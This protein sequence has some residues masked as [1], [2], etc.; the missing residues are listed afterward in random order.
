MAFYNGAVLTHTI[1]PTFQSRTRT[2]FRINK[3]GLYFT[4]WRLV[5]MGVYTTKLENEDKRFVDNLGMWAVSSMYLLDGSTELSRLV[6]KEWKAWLNRVMTN[7]DAINMKDLKGT[8][9]GYTLS[10]DTIVGTAISST[11]ILYPNSNSLIKLEEEN[12]PHLYVDLRKFL[13]FLS[14]F[15][16]MHTSVFSNLRLVVEWNY[17]GL[18]REQGNGEAGDFSNITPKLVVDEVLDEKLVSKMATQL[19]SNPVSWNEVEVEKFVLNSVQGL[20]DADLAYQSAVY[21]SNGFQNKTVNRLLLQKRY[22]GV[23]LENFSDYYSVKLWKE[24]LNFRVNG[25]DLLPNSGVVDNT[26]YA[27]SLTTDSWGNY[28]QTQFSNYSG[29]PQ[30]NFIENVN[31]FANSTHYVGVVVGQKINSL[32]MEIK[33]GYKDTLSEVENGDVELLL[34]GEVRKT[35]QKDPKLG[36]QILYS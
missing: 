5:D 25:S 17:N 3:E 9:M 11:S 20:A 12:T 19:L 30:T 2:E 22:R 33:R 27:V 13:P 28:V 35:I 34:F 16:Y 1:E 6:N 36:Y 31:A 29:I 23:K 8:S 10:P 32:Q 4:N 15:A 14:A 7:E 24:N 21:R 18:V 26:N